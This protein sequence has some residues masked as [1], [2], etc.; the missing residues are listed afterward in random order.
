MN[1]F[2]R[3][4]IAALALLGA[5]MAAG[6]SSVSTRQNAGALDRPANL[7]VVVNVPVSMNLLRDDYVEE[8]FAYRVAAALHEQGFRG[9]IKYVDFPDDVNPNIPM[10]DIVLQEWRVDHVGSV[11]C[12]FFATLRTPSGTKNLGLF[13]GTTLMMWS[14]RDWMARADGFEDA[15]RD[16]LSNLGARITESG[17][18]TDMRVR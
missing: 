17:L 16:A 3:P 10:L 5:G 4:M 2:I 18:L 15:A 6:C 14:R 12:V 8:A 7:Q 1:H 13:S 9:S 11:D